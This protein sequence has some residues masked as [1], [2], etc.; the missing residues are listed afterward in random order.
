[1]RTQILLSYIL[2]TSR[3]WKEDTMSNIIDP[4]LTT[5]LGTETI[6]CI[7]IGLL[8]VQENVASR[9]TMA[10]IVS[11]LNSHYVT[12][13]LPSRPAYYLRNS[14]KDTTEGTQS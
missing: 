14:E 4:M 8:C 1:M 5:G 3:N 9:P 13:S 12:L 7:H 2:V 6:R 10:S 11:M